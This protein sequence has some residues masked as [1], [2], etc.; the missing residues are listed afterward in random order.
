MCSTKH[1]VISLVLIEYCIDKLETNLL[2]YIYIF[3]KYNI[4]NIFVKIFYGEYSNTFTGHYEANRNR[5]PG[6]TTLEFV[7]RLVDDSRRVV[8]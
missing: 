7:G 5:K 6:F 1:F 3:C 2:I 4:H 8:L